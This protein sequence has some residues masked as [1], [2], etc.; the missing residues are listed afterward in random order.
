M[1]LIQTVFDLIRPF[2]PL[3][4]TILIVILVLG[5]LNRAHKRGWQG[6]PDA[7]FRYQMIMLV[8][9]LI[10]G[11]AVIVALPF[12]ESLRGQLLSLIGILLSAA[13][14]LSSTTFIGN[15]MAGIMLK[16]IRSARPGDFVTAGD[17]SGR[18]SEMG[19]LHTEVQTEFRDLVTIPNLVMVTQPLKVVRSSGTIISAEVS[20]G[21]DVPNGKVSDLLRAAAEKCGLS[22]VFVHVRVLGDFAVTYRVAGLLE[23]VQSLISSRSALRVAMLDALHEAGIEVVSPTFMNTRP[24]PDD[25]RFIPKLLAQTPEPSQTQVEDVAFDKAEQAASKEEIRAQIEAVDKEIEAAK[26]SKREHF[27]RGDSEA[28][29]SRDGNPKHADQELLE[30]RKAR[31]IALLEAAEDGMENEDK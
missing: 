17:I 16:A 31:L 12:G 20:L 24:L 11:L 2:V 10:G 13:I 27:K 19:L 21:Y 15:V 25:R 28:E 18:I 23:N 14:A 26:H 1:E 30:A 7:A 5:L 3:L 9:G 22:D 4:A 6:N 8:I 29:G